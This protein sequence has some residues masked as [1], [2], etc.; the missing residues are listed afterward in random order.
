MLLTISSI[1][2]SGLLSLEQ[3]VGLLLV[4][5]LIKRFFDNLIITFSNSRFNLFD[6]IFSYKSKIYQG[7]VII[8]GRVLKLK[9]GRKLLLVLLEIRVDHVLSDVRSCPAHEY[10]VKDQQ[11]NLEDV[12]VLVT[13]EDLI[14]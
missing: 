13:S 8:I 6:F 2:F 7:L 4:E 9:D 11:G 3:I 5:I 14:N 12:P 1:R 10:L